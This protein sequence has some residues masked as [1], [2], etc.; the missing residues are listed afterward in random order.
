MVKILK[1]LIDKGIGFGEKDSDVQ[2]YYDRVDKILAGKIVPKSLRVLTQLVASKLIPFGRVQCIFDILSDIFEKEIAF[3]KKIADQVDDDDAWIEDDE[4]CRLADS[5][6]E[7][8]KKLVVEGYEE[9]YPLALEEVQRSAEDE[10]VHN[11]YV[12][13]LFSELFKKSIGHKEGFDV[14]K[15][16]IS[17]S[18]DFHKCNGLGLLK[19]LVDIGYKEVYSYALAL[20]QDSI[21][22]SGDS[23]SEMIVKIAASLVDKGIGCDEMERTLSENLETEYFKISYYFVLRG[24][25]KSD[26]YARMVPLLIKLLEKGRSLELAEEVLT[27]I[28][29]KNKKALELANALEKMK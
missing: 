13:S 18:S 1:S 21:F 12:V 3:K 5:A 6:R 22:A 25:S 19:E 10:E 29:F 14:A 2:F 4:I 9:F 16:W 27:V 23:V 17:Q 7:L 20:C 26:Y 24:L 15:K 11:F 28:S 8:L